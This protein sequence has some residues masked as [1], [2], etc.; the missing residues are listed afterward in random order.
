MD[1]LVLNVSVEHIT[2]VVLYLHCHTARVGG[3][4]PGHQT[5]A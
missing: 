5:K 1:L 3:V 4:I 2:E